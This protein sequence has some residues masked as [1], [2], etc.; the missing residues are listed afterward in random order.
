M[1]AKH[2][3]MRLDSIPSIVP[4]SMTNALYKTAL[5]ERD[6]FNWVVCIQMYTNNQIRF[7]CE[8]CSKSSVVCAYGESQGKWIFDLI[9]D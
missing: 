4:A 6:A 8:M 7:E 1:V 5:A 9:R 3:Y 2:E